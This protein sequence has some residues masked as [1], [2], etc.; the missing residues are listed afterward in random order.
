MS[1]K[2]FLW[3]PKKIIKWQEQNELRR[4]I[5]HGRA[6]S[7]GKEG[8]IGSFAVEVAEDLDETSVG[9][10]GSKA[11]KSMIEYYNS[12]RTPTEVIFEVLKRDTRRF[13]LLLKDLIAKPESVDEKKLL[14][15]KKINQMIDDR[16]SKL[17]YLDFASKK[18]SGSTLYEDIKTLLETAISSTSSIKQKFGLAIES[19]EK[20]RQNKN[21][22][23]KSYHLKQA[24]Y[25]FFIAI[26]DLSGKEIDKNSE[27]QKLLSDD[28]KLEP[29]LKAALKAQYD[30]EKAK[31]KPFRKPAKHQ[32]TLTKLEWLKKINQL[33]LGDDGILMGYPKGSKYLT[34]LIS[35]LRRNINMNASDPYHVSASGKLIINKPE[36]YETVEAALKDLKKRF[37]KQVYAKKS[38][39]FDEEHSCD[40]AEE[41]VP[42]H[43]EIGVNTGGGGGIKVVTAATGIK[44]THKSLQTKLEEEMKKIE[45]NG[46]AAA[47]IVESGGGTTIEGFSADIFG[48]GIVGRS[49]RKAI[50]SAVAS[51]SD[52]D[53]F[54]SEYEAE[55]TDDS[56]DED[57]TLKGNLSSSKSA[58]RRATG[59]GGGESSRKRMAVA[60]KN[61]ATDDE[62][63]EDLVSDKGGGG[64]ANTTGD[65]FGEGNVGG[66]GVGDDAENDDWP[67]DEDCTLFVGGGAM[68]AE[69]EESG[70]EILPNSSLS[71]VYWAKQV[72]DA[73]LAVNRH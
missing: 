61:N 8:G 63:K 45:T 66:G 15:L 72:K 42:E 49:R 69:G 71:S 21:N 27:I 36:M 11:N 60:R 41:T 33:E 40:G 14:V 47:P 7:D 23:F 37:E 1:R 53:E 17:P 22:D 70:D 44:I 52:E 46:D 50:A 4:R 73:T 26:L 34:K 24:S 2:G 54:G 31:E 56:R 67:F 18:T 30:L 20:S 48:G 51:L 62:A 55:A 68:C 32:P 5:I 64:G 38:H 9:K 43:K 12:R 13:Y 35:T 25:H 3:Q 65:E 28:N 10:G 58:K 19:L 16:I 6:E 29:L 59:E 57:Y 39:S